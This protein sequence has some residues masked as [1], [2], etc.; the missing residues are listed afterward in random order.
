MNYMQIYSPDIQYAEMNVNAPAHVVET[1]G[2]TVSMTAQDLLNLASQKLLSI[3]EPAIPAAASAN[4]AAG[5]G[6]SGTFTFTFSD[7]AGFANLTVLDVLINSAL[8]GRTACYVAFVPSGPTS[9]SVYLVDNSGDAGGPYS[10]MTLP[11][12]Q[13]VSNGQCTVKGTGSSVSSSGNAVTLTLAITFASGFAGNQV[14][15]LSA[16]DATGNSGWQVQ[17]TWNVPGLP[18]AGPAVSGMNPARTSTL[19]QTYTFTFTDTNGWQD[20]SVANILINGAIDGRHA[21]YLALVPATSSLLLVDDAGDAGGPYSGMVLPGSGSV[22]NGQCTISGTG[23]SVAG[24]GNTLT[25][26]LAVTFSQSFGGEQIF[27]LSARNSSGQNTGWQAVGTAG[28]P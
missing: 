2:A 11:G 7:S 22:S 20:I 3:A 12:S 19:S 9:G 14:F 26:M 10:G 25:L 1:S 13:S 5:S 16:Q 24:S 17:G 8:D 27:Y 28:V 15:Y 23:S 4:P 6:T 21:C 18:A